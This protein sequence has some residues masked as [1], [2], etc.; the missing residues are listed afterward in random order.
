MPSS[1][2]ISI[3]LFRGATIV[4]MILVNNPGDG[5]QAYGPLKHAAWNGWTPADLVFPFFLF[6]VGAAMAF[7]FNARSER[8]QSR[9][10]LLAHALWRGAVL[11][12]I[13]LLLNGFPDHYHL[14][15]LRVYGILQRI[16]ICYV[17]AAIL[18]LWSDRRGWI[19]ATIACLAG[20]WI[21][22]RFVPVPGF[23]VPGRDIPLLDPDRSLVAWLDR[24]L[25]SGHLYEGTRDPEGL[26]STIPAIATCILGLLAGDWLRSRRS[27]IQKIW[28]LAVWGIVGIVAGEIW[29]FWLPVNKKLWTSSYTI[30]TAGIAVVCMALCYWILDVRRRRERWIMPFLVFGMNAI[31]AYVLAEAMSAWLDSVHVDPSTTGHDFLYQNLFEPWASSALASLLYAIA[32]VVFCWLCMWLLYRKGIFL[33]V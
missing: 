28:G 24:K 19:V 12:V 5:P 33:K 26:L 27:A 16:A 6:I 15:T 11:F 4:A 31:S 29:N 2:L 32:I 3:D 20:Y 7:S 8:G 10:K 1:R 30:F 14:A 18:A 17:I 13:G 9:G 23:G 22:L 25:L 21:L